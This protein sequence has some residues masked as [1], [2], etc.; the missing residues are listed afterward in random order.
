MQDGERSSGCSR[1]FKWR[2]KQ[3]QQP[4]RIVA[5]PVVGDVQRKYTGNKTT[6]TK[7]NLLTFIPKSLFEQYRWVLMW[8]SAPIN[9]CAAHNALYHP[10]MP[11]V[12]RLQQQQQ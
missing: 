10:L 7:Y 6:T 11:V 1:L 2:R 12:Q 4:E 8:S 5:H 3:K 9:N